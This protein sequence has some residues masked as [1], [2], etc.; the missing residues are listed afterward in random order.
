MSRRGSGVRRSCGRVGR[1][2]VAGVVQGVELSREVG[3]P[4][5]EL[6]YVGSGLLE[7]LGV[8]WGSEDAAVNGNLHVNA[9]S[10]QV[11]A[12]G[13]FMLS[14][15]N[16]GSGGDYDRD[17]GT[18]EIYLPLLGRMG[19]ELGACEG[20][21]GGTGIIGILQRKGGGFGRDVGGKSIG[22]DML[23]KKLEWLSAG[24][25][26]VGGKMWLISKLI[27]VRGNFMCGVREVK[28]G[29]SG[30][31]GGG[32]CD[33]KEVSLGDDPDEYLSRRHFQLRT[34]GVFTLRRLRT[35][36]AFK[37]RRVCFHRKMFPDELKGAIGDSGDEEQCR[38][39][40]NGSMEKAWT[41]PRARQKISAHMA[42]AEDPGSGVE[43]GHSHPRYERGT[44]QDENKSSLEYQCDG[45]MVKHIFC[46]R[47]LAVIAGGEKS[48]KKDTDKESVHHGLDCRRKYLR[49]TGAT[50][51]TRNLESGPRTLKSQ[52]PA[53]SGERNGFTADTEEVKETY[54]ELKVNLSEQRAPGTAGRILVGGE[55]SRERISS[56][57]SER[58]RAKVQVK[59]A[60]MDALAPMGHLSNRQGE[61]L[62]PQ[63]VGESSSEQNARDT[64]KSWIQA[65]LTEVDKSLDNI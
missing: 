28:N 5:F 8:A 7:L 65:G 29:W 45:Q 4:Q 59:E 53:S 12:A 22:T 15:R 32:E 34:L 39:H 51:G 44:K 24:R 41:K 26:I 16:I 46:Q 20:S 11:Q 27:E 14:S 50:S 47:D 30:V 38:M 48:D 55:Y 33:G 13:Q 56:E 1:E 6:V 23:G 2:D 37:L 25:K 43:T 61:F 58:W 9:C 40:L 62:I 49:A 64:G 63:I 42:R 3:A 21:R 52:R 57:K 60:K 54:S 10:A 36:S 35:Y 31:F 17:A 19:M 18:Q